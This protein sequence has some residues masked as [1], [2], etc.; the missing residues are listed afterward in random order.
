MSGLLCTIILVLVVATHC[1]NNSTLIEELC[2]NCTS[3]FENFFLK[4]VWFPIAPQ[5]YLCVNSSSNLS[6]HMLIVDVVCKPEM[7]KGITKR[8][9]VKLFDPQ[10]LTCGCDEVKPE[11]RPETSHQT[12]DIAL[13]IIAVLV[14]ITTGIKLLPGRFNRLNGLIELIFQRGVVV[15]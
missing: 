10:L 14:F 3:N 15:Q 8:R 9:A 11:E 12:I 6:Q 5:E 7:C 1:K 4:T 13:I 2:I